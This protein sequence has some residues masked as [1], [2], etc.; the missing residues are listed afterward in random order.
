MQPTGASSGG[1][2]ACGP[3]G[4]TR[5]HMALIYSAGDYLGREA[6]LA[7]AGFKE[8]VAGEDILYAQH[9]AEDRD[10]HR[11]DR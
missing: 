4:P 6:S 3:L 11:L 1:S 2:S 9:E 7:S 10:K 8:D 5:L